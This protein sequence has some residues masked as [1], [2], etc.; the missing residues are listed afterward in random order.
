MNMVFRW[1]GMVVCSVGV[2]GTALAQAQPG[3][4]DEVIRQLDVSSAK[5]QSAE[6]DF[7]WDLY[8]RVVKQTTSQTGTIYFMRKGGSTEMGAQIVPPGAKTLEFKDGKL[9]VFDPTSNH[10]IEIAAGKNSAQYE[11]FL[12][13]GF[14]GSGTALTKA[15]TITD[16]GTESMSD[17]AQTVSVEKLDLVAKE[18]SVRNMFTHIVIWVDPARDVS[19]KQQFFTPSED[20]RTAV[21]TKIRY[22]S[23]VDTKPFAIRTDK[24]TT[25]DRR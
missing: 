9:R 5:F 11:S 4:L 1:L 23:K 17:G 24:Q 8:E 7:R 15:W 22:N 12:T 20:V 21:Y 10:L 3:H 2:S 16:L 14:G 13:L 25:V 18:Q 19:L 6:A